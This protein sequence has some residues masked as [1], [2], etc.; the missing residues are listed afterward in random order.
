MGGR[1][2]GLIRANFPIPAWLN[3]SGDFFWLSPTPIEV[4]KKTGNPKTRKPAEF[5]YGNP[6]WNSWPRLGDAVEATEDRPY[7]CL[8]SPEDVPSKAPPS[9]RSLSWSWWLHGL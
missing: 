2:K 8:I 9:G 4:G 7:L 1:E 5:P 6:G 3:P